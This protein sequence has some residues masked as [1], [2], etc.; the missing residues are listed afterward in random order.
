MM[1]DGGIWLPLVGFVVEVYDAER[2][3]ITGQGDTA[4]EG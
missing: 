3:F 2:R 1:F 4:W